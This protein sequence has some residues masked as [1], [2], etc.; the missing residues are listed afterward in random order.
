MAELG[1]SELAPTAEGTEILRRKRTLQPVRPPLRNG[2]GGLPPA[3]LGQRVEQG[4]AAVRMGARTADGAPEILA[5]YCE[6]ITGTRPGGVS[7]LV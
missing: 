5:A 1:I 2:A 7:G 6:R 4:P 3:K